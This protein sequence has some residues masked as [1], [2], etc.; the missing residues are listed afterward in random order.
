MTWEVVAFFAT[1]IPP[2]LMVTP[3]SFTF[4]FKLHLPA[5]SN[6]I[7]ASITFALDD[8]IHLAM[9]VLAMPACV[10]FHCSTAQ[11]RTFFSRVF[12]MC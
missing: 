1:F 2:A 8:R 10:L 7:M 12:A 11:S 3:K 4:L 6:A 9:S 5:A